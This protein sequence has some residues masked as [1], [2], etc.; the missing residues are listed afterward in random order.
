MNPVW[1]FPAKNDEN[2][3]YRPGSEYIEKQQ[4]NSKQKI[5]QVEYGQNRIAKQKKTK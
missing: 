4:R 2:N 3:Q 1:N 5:R